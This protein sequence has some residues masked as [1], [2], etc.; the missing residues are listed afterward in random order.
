MLIFIPLMKKKKLASDLNSFN[1][2]LGCELARQV[3]LKHWFDSPFMY[4]ER[5]ADTSV[6]VPRSILAMLHE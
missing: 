4:R 2:F 5:N 3:S 6:D 1:S